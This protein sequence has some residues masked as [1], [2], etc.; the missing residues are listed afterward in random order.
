MEVKE[1]LR[2]EQRGNRGDGTPMQQG[3]SRVSAREHVQFLFES[4]H[5][6]G[7]MLTEDHNFLCSIMQWV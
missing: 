7:A 1:E 4:K 2:R 6:T 5:L 3:T